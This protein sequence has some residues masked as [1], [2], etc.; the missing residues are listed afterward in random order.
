MIWIMTINGKVDVLVDDILEKYTVINN[1]NREC[2]SFDSTNQLLCRL[3]ELVNGG[4]IK[5][6]IA[7]SFQ[8]DGNELNWL[9]RGVIQE[10]YES[11]FKDS[12]FFVKLIRALL[13]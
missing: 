12:A 4:E 13:E 8:Y 7:P 9:A 3:I 1:N 10:F 5:V 11:G 2:W 6:M